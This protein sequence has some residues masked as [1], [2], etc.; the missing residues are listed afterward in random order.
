MKDSSAKRASSDAFVLGGFVTVYS[1]LYIF[2]FYL[3]PYRL[4]L[5]NRR[6]REATNLA[7]IRYR[8]LHGLY[9]PFVL[10]ASYRVS[11]VVLPYKNRAHSA[12]RGLGQADQGRD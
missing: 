4:F 11:Y 12:L 8:L 2:T 9:G 7:T 6:S 5:F 1:H 10:L 3:R